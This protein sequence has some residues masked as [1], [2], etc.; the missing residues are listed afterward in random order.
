MILFDCVSK[1]YGA[2]LVL[3]NVNLMI[4]GGEFVTIIGSSGAGKTTL[5]NTLIGAE[6]I[7]GGSITVDGYE[8]TSMTPA[9]LQFY[10]R[11]IGIIFQDYKLLPQKTVYENVAFAMEVCGCLN[12]EMA[13]RV[14]EVLDMVGLTAQRNQFPY[15]L[16][17]GENQRTAIARA[18]VHHPKLLIADEPTGNLDPENTRSIIELLLKINAGGTTVILASH[19]KEMVNYINRRVVH[20]EDGLILSDQ[21]KAGYSVDIILESAQTAG[22][23][24]LHIED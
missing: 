11:K 3:N 18:L 1:Q 20:L 22:V 7:D 12:K 9:V 13:G 15:Q 5:I 4:E 19:D 17:G 10:R 8:I 6:K 16:S 14:P 23:M 21:K 2:K 24:E